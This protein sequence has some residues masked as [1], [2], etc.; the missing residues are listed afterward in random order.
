MMFLVVDILKGFETQTA[1]CL[2]LAEILQIPMVIILNKID[3]IEESKREINISKVT[4]KIQKTLSTTIFS[5]SKVIPISA[6]LKL[7]LDIL[8]ETM[9][10][11]AIKIT[12]KRNR[13]H[14]FIFA[15]DHC[16]QIKGK[17]TVLSGTVLQGSAKVN[18]SIE[19]PE[20]K[21]EKKIKSMQMFKNPIEEALPGSRCGICISQFDA[22]LLERGLICKNQSVQYIYSTVIKV[23][24]VKHF[25]REIKSKAKFHIS[26]GHDTAIASIIIFSS[27]DLLKN[28]NWTSEY[29]YE[30]SIIDEPENPKELFALLEFEYPVLVYD[31]MLLIGSKLDIEKSN[32]CRLAFWDKV[33][34]Q[35]SATDKTYQQTFLPNLKVFKTKFREG[36]IQR[37]VNERE[38]I[39]SN[40]FKKETNRGLFENMKCELSTG[41][42]GTIA[43]TFGQSSKIRLQFMN[44]LQDSTIEI[45]KQPKNNIKVILK[46]KK[47]VF[48]RNH[49]MIQ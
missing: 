13:D 35:T 41:E 40:L 24:K 16:F 1:E 34:M 49:K 5:D 31:S 47:F 33:S 11:E 23:N 44:V 27:T 20:L 48:D 15:F 4:K 9:N 10:Q 36:A 43:G 30:E 6:T 39:V 28:F 8:L 45:L 17:G 26:L 42:V 7:N 2:I 18:D 21:I 25:K 22:K 29:R 46:L 14:P 38:V 3:S 37:Y 12:L 19:I 32:T